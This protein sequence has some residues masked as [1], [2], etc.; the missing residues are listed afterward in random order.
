MDGLKLRLQIVFGVLIVVIALGTL[1]FKFIEGLSLVD[2]FYFSIVTITTVGYG[3]IHPSTEPGKILAMV[4][5]ISGV[6]TFLAVVA[7]ATEILMS[8][9]EREIRRQKTNMVLRTFFSDIGI[10]LLKFF[11]T[12][13]PH[14]ENIGKD[15]KVTK[16]WSKREF[17]TAKRH[18][19]IYDFSVDVHRSSLES[20][21]RFLEERGDNLLRNL[22]N[23]VL[24][25]HESFA[26]VLQAII[27]LR[28][29]FLLR[30]DLNNLPESDNKH[31]AGDIRRAY[32][33]L[34][35]QWLDY[36]NYLK[37][38]YPYLF[39]LATRTNPFDPEASPIVT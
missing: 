11:T 10:R 35:Y 29:E 7:N 9:R 33:R 15:L 30:E 8:R 16:D 24:L 4:L 12:F 36:M 22:E 28:D 21:S 26:G 2:A 14:I 23:P 34:A 27:H 1:G 38:D 31:I 20:L 39:N 6:G 25:E 18:L 19:E 32:R 17:S 3:D 5:I 37:A 13:D